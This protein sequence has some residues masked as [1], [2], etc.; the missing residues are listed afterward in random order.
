[1]GGQLRP[2]K[3]VAAPHARVAGQKRVRAARGWAG[4]SSPPLPE[5]YRHGRVLLL[6]AHDPKMRLRD[7]AASLRITEL[8]A[9][10]VVAD[11][12]AAGSG[13]PRHAP[14]QRAGMPC[15]P[16]AGA[17]SAELRE[18]VAALLTHTDAWHDAD[19]GR[20][21]TPAL[22]AMASARIGTDDITLRMAA[23]SLL[24]VL[25]R[26]PL[27][28]SPAVATTATRLRRALDPALT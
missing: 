12:T 19:P 28:H 4:S 18:A 20:R 22:R 8:S 9:C 16:R 26:H 5:M 7:I 10:G 17:Y 24:A 15:N 11:L 3:A 23:R 13:P 25:A 27:T 2:L 6:L 1:V 14:G 21:F